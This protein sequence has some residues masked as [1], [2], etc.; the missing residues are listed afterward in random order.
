MADRIKGITIEIG[1]DT[2]GLNKALSGTNKEI[3]NTQ[4]QLKDVE[5]LLKLDPSN[6]ELLRQKQKLLA[7]AVQ[8]T[9]AKLETLKTAE[10]QAQDQFK[11]GKISEEQ[12][13]ALK[14]EIIATEQ[15]LGKL[16]DQAGKSSVALQKLGQ[17][18]GKIQEFGGKV[19]AAGQELSKVS[20]G[21][22]AVGAASV[23]A[24]ET[25]DEAYDTIAKGTGATGEALEDLQSSFDKVFSSIPTEASTAGSAIADINTRF[26]FTGDV[27][28]DC[29]RKFIQFGEVNNTDVSTAIANVSRYMGDASIESSKYGEV[30][31]QLT[32]ASQASGLGVD[33]L[34][35]SLTKYGAPMRALGLTTQESIAILAGWEKAGVNTEIAF[36]GMKKAIGTWGKAGKDASQEFKKTLDEIAKAPDIAKATTKAIEVFGQKA[37][38]DLADAI[39]GGRFEYEDFLNVIEKS[40]GQLE[41]TF[42]DTLDPIDDVKVSMQALTTQ[43]A[44]LGGTLLKTLS[45]M[46]TNLVGKLKELTSWFEGL[47]DSQK[48]TVVKIGLLV[49]AIGPLLVIVG[50]VATGIGALVTLL[51]GAGG[52]ILLTV[53]AIGELAA[54]FYKAK[55]ESDSYY[56]NARK[57]TD[58]ERENAEQIN[59]LSEAYDQMIERRDE[60]VK[61]I[62]AEALKERSLAE[63]LAR[64]TDE[65]GNVKEGYEDRAK[66]ILGELS[67]ALGQEYTLTG[68]QIDQYQDLIGEIDTLIQKKQANALLSAREAD[69]ADAIKN[70]IDATVAYY[71]AQKDVATAQEQYN[72]ANQRA[73]EYQQQ[74]NALLQEA[75]ET[76]DDSIRTSQQLTA[77]SNDMLNAQNEAQGYKDRL[78]ELNGELSE[79]E[80]AWTGYNAVISN[81]EGLSAAIISG[82]QEKI[83][84]ALLDLK[85][86]FQTAENSTRESLERQVQ[87]AE[88]NYAALQSAVAAGA[89]AAVEEA[90]KQAKALVD[91]SKEELDK[92]PSVTNQAAKDAAQAII[93]GNGETRSAGSEFARGLA[94]G[95]SDGTNDVKGAAGKIAE[96]GVE[97][98]RAALDSH[99]PSRVMHGIGNDYTTGFAGGITEK[100]TEVAAAAEQVAESATNGIKS[101]IPLADVWGSDMMAGYIRGIR[102]KIGELEQACQSV[103][104]TVYDYMHFTRPEKGPLRNYEEWMPH[105]MQGLAAGIKENEGTVG[106]AAGSAAGKIGEELAAG[107]ADGVRQNKKNAKKSA[108]ELAKAVLDAAQKKLKNE[109][110]YRELSLSDEV[111][112]W[113]SVRKQVTEG[114]D[115]R[116]SA[117]EKYFKAKQDL[118]KKAQAAEEKYTDNVAKAYEDLNKKIK[119]LNKEYRDAVD[120]RASEIQNAYGL[121]DEFS[122]DTDLTSDDLLNNLQSQVDGLDE[123]RS[124]LDN[125][126]GRGISKDLLAELQ[127]LGPQSA[128]QIRLLTQMTD[129]QLDQYV[130]LFRQKNKIARK[131]AVEELAPMRRDIA[132]QI[133]DLKFQTERELAD[134]Q[135]QYIESMAE[136][137]VALNQPAENMKLMMAQNAVEMVSGLATSIQAE[138]GSTENTER[139]KAIANNILNSTGTLQADMQSVGQNAIAGIIVG[140]QSKEA[141]LYAAAEGIAQRVTQAMQ[142]TFQIHSPSAVMREKIGKNLMLGLRDGMEK[143]K[144]L[145]TS[146]VKI[147]MNFTGTADRE[148]AAGQAADMSGVVD[149]L[150]A[151]LPE[152]AQQKYITL[153]GKTLVGQ[154]VSEM[155]CQLVSTQAVQGRNK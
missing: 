33:K 94:Y 6:T 15:E 112:Y 126:A 44:K 25:V 134:Y 20:A 8:E 36:S 67:D 14:R 73:A 140:L 144:E 3:R 61:G 104:G 38:P 32:A 19:T 77:L 74:L 66:Y 122:M 29:T 113:D 95:I 46:I 31:D 136:L 129:D 102:S 146:S 4:S 54:A 26:G 106:A 10:K 70:Q 27:L 131:Q 48:E 124:N 34:S 23:A 2:T 62:E 72:A 111:D 109:E 149:V 135:K 119:A 63:E 11:Q 5:R 148:G 139:F 39:Q 110:V 24:W 80:T 153:N 118:N 90:A 108:E 53:A 7:D 92:L 42:N 41:Q 151:Y 21:L 40:E 150:N 17:A 51:A 59:N 155:N 141:E 130:S 101:T 65:N 116:I 86:D 83:S 22:A 64:I 147:G 117:D 127:D 91:R 120:S 107:I 132:D 47:N 98:A 57:L 75:N 143:Y 154:T 100:T 89:P 16:E 68:N 79:A 152:I 58:Q 45:P 105:M 43:G 50:Q 12:Y 87:A 88:E 18:G 82:D 121:F 56:N 35:D 114:T 78:E 123:W 97:A 93:D 84:E 103:A 52:P 128:A 76:G 30:L 28:E 81:Y 37:G 115:A 69:Y 138:A 13:N 133:S 60:A 137:G 85:T 142:D 71:N 49:A 96:A 145:A 9:G 55:K 99:S 1:G 125:L